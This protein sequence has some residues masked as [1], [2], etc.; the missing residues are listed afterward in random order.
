MTKMINPRPL[1]GIVSLRANGSGD[2]ATLI[3]ALNKDWTEFKATMAEKDKEI[4]KRFDDVVTTEKLE[5]INSSVGDLT[6]AL[7]DVNAKLAGITLNGNGND[8]DDLSEADR[9]YRATFEEWFRSGEGESKVKA[10][11]RAGDITA[12]YSV[13]DSDKGGYTAP[14]EWDRTITDK[15]V[16]ISPMRRYASKQN[17]TGQGFKKLYNVHGTT[18][19]WVGETSERAQTGGSALVEYAF[20]FG[21]I[22]AMP[23][24]TQRILEDSEINIAA[25]LSGEVNIEFAVQEGVAFVSGDGVNKAKGVLKYTATDEAAL[26]AAQRHPLGP[27]AEVRTG[28]ANTITAD[29]LVDLIYDLP[30]DRSQG[31]ALYANRK[32]HATIR[33][34]KD[35][36]GNFL[37][38][39]PFQAGQPAQVLGQ[40][41]NELS[42]LPDVAANSIPLIFGNME[43]GYRI[44]DRVGMSVLR[45]PYT[46]KPYVLFY[47]TKRVGGGLWNPEWLRYHRVAAP[48]A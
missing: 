13:G 43:Q 29:G 27:I 32:T 11:N 8:K 31:A 44:F 46:Q 25:W 1:R 45:D 3:E 47:T 30:E 14:I 34:M 36:Q 16:E 37:W 41:I 24:A 40:P 39:A 7:D 4:T 17:V 28:N 6:K 12:A 19:G 15:R 23:A 9:E 21:E 42:G 20:S 48:A 35:G 5:R 33:K 18:S 22:Y 26:P 2:V 10:A 38:Q